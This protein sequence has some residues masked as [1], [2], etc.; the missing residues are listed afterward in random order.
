MSFEDAAK[1]L[2][3]HVR[4]GGHGFLTISKEQLRQRFEI[5]RLTDNLSEQIVEALDEVELTISPYPSAAG[6]NLRV[7]DLLHP[8]GAAALAVSSP[9]ESTDAALL[10]LSD[11]VSRSHA[12]QALRSDDVP[13]LDALRLLL[14]LSLG[15]EP[16]GWEDLRNDRHGSELARHI[17]AELGLDPSL[18]ESPAL[19]RLAALADCFRPLER[20][21]SAAELLPPGVSEL[22]AHGLL[23][24]FGATQ[25]RMAEQHAQLL[26]AIGRTL[27]HGAELP[28]RQIEVGL[29]GLR[30]RRERTV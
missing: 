9:D 2:A 7:Y 26:A 5:G 1:Q 12:A 27:L 30:R 25:R 13:W 10:K 23:E 20:T 16:D 24:V 11:L 28:A 29:L 8:L 6:Y 21:P 22:N 3:Q 18:P 14:Q 4:A 15:R 19:V 17:A